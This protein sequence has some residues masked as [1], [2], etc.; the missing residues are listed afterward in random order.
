[1]IR[2]LIYLHGKD[3]SIQSLMYLTTQ[4]NFLSTYYIPHAVSGAA[5]NEAPKFHKG[6]QITYSAQES[7][8]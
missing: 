8:E 5:H 6:F 2:L 3:P 4:Q 7:T 1:M